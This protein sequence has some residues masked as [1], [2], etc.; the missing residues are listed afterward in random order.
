[1][2][3]KFLKKRGKLKNHRASKKLDKNILIHHWNDFSEIYHS[4]LK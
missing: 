2:N 3:D 4:V 1:M